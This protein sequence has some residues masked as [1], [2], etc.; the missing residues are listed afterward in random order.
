MSY[1]N[2]FAFYIF[3]RTY[4]SMYFSKN[5]GIQ[6][7]TLELKWARPGTGQSSTKP[8]VVLPRWKKAEFAI[9][10]GP[11]NKR[12]VDGHIEVS[13]CYSSKLSL[14]GRGGEGR[15]RHGEFYSASSRWCDNEEL[16]TWWS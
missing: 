5:L 9:V 3:Y 16:F 13:G 1:L 14:A 6:L 7:N 4:I 15:R 12:F 2:R 10:T 8:S 11:L